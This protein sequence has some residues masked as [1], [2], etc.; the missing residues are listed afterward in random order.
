MNSSSFRC[1]KC[2]STLFTTG[3]IIEHNNPIGDSVYTDSECK[4]GVCTS[5]FISNTSWMEG[6]TEQT[7]RII[8]PNKS[9]DSKL[10]Y[11]S[12]FG[13]R[14]SCGYWQTPSFQ[15]HKSKVDFLPNSLRPNQINMEIIE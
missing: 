13:A 10:G 3:H 15:I 2:G 6:Y 8:C 12:W 1:K 9:C 14:C 7:G 5:Y 4:Q 11:Y